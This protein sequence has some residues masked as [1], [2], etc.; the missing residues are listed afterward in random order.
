M[1]YPEP[2]VG[3]ED[4]RNGIFAGESGGD[5]DALFGFSNRSGGQFQDVRLTS[6]TAG[7]AAE[8][9]APSGQ[10]GQWVKGQVG[11]VAT[12][13]GAYQV[14]GTTLRSAIDAGVVSPDERM[15]PEVQD[16]I[17]RWVLDTQGTGA[18]EGYKGPQQDYNPSQKA[19]T[20]DQRMAPDLP[21]G[22][23]FNP[24]YPQQNALAK[25]EEPQNRLAYEGQD[26]RAFMIQPMQNALAKF[27]TQNPYARTT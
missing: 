17:G 25:P 24:Q 6:M 10:Y 22:T 7:Q 12:P 9:S 15:T 2:W 27:N 14:V 21:M 23:P 4:I 20:S 26:P 11:R 3:K 1:D 18:W 5:Y 16:R 13:M 8:F 19:Y